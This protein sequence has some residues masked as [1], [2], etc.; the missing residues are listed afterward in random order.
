M[1]EYNKNFDDNSI[2]P[3]FIKPENDPA[4]GQVQFCNN[5]IKDYLKKEI[6]HVNKNFLKYEKDKSLITISK[7]Y[8]IKYPMLCYLN[9]LIS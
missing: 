6:A 3:F 7:A 2:L 9:T 8:K 4:R 5:F 1:I